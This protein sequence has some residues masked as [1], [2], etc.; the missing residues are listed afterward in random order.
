MPAYTEAQFQKEVTDM[1]DERN[2]LWHHCDA[3]YRCSGHNGLPDLLLIGSSLLYVELKS[4][5]G[6]L[7]GDQNM[8]KWAI[9]KAGGSHAVWK[10]RDLFNG[11][12]E[13]AL[14]NIAP[15]GS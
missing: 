2:I 8:Y 12:V 14:D 7:T 4:S 6:H 10:P 1:C 15:G 9:I 3:A 11:V 13:A 5:W